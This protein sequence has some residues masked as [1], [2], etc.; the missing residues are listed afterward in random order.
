MTVIVLTAC[1]EGLRGQLTRWLLEVA[2]GVFVGHVSARV[3]ALLWER[4]VEL[5]GHGRGLMIYSARCEQ[6]LAF[7]VCGHDWVPTDF[8]GIQLMMRP[9]KV[10]LRPGDRPV[11]DHWSIASRRRKFTGRGPR[12]AG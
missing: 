3:R 6:R 2:P 8:D 7:E 10:P 11:P 4:V 5:I 9:P 12:P 1:P